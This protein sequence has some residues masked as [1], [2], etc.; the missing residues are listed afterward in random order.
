MSNATLECLKQPIITSMTDKSSLLPVPVVLAKLIKFWDTWNGRDK[1]CRTVQ[2]F[3]KFLAHYYAEQQKLTGVADL[4]VLVAQYKA[5]S[6]QLSLA[7]K[8][9]RFFRW[10]NFY[11]KL[12]KLLT[13]APD[14]SSAASVLNYLADIVNYVCFGVYLAY[15]GYVFLGKAG[16]LADKTIDQK[17][18]TANY[19]W[20]FALAGACFGDI[21]KISEGWAKHRKLVSKYNSM[22]TQENNEKEQE[23]AKNAVEIQRKAISKLY[24]TFAKDAFDLLVPLS[25]NEHASWVPNSGTC[26]LLG[27]VSSL[28]G[29]YQ[30]WPDN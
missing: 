2:Y 9:F 13:K 1:T 7:R 24:I 17:A 30:A 6:S 25:L 10:I 20:F 12:A 5:L 11:E 4:K 27:T 23:E 26:G 29:A 8:A 28:I 22:S 14:G 19:W 15:D 16:F 18:K 21:L 3:A